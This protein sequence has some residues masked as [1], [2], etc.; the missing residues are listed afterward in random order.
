[1]NNN[2]D[3]TCVKG[4]GIILMVLG[5]CS[6]S[7]PYVTQI[8]YMFHMPL[9]FFFSGYCFKE[10]YYYQ[11]QKFLLRRIKGL[12][13][14]YVKWSLIFLLFHNLFFYLNIYNSTYG[15][16]MGSDHIYSMQE[17]LFKAYTITTHMTGHEQ[18][19]GGYWFLR[20]LF[21][22]SILSFFSLFVTHKI[23]KFYHC[24]ELYLEVGVLLLMVTLSLLISYYKIVIPYFHCGAHATHAA[25]FYLIGH[26]FKKYK[27]RTLTKKE[28]IIAFG[29]VILGSFF[30]RC[31]MNSLYYD[32]SKMIPFIVTAVVGTW[33]LY[34]LPWSSMKGG[35][36]L[37]IA[38][39]H[40][41]PILTWHFLCFK[42]ITLCIIFMY[43]LSINHL[44]EYPVIKYFAEK[45]W[46]LLYFFSGIG[47]PLFISIYIGRIK[48][49]Y[50]K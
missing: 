25:T 49:I 18:L 44:A 43:G 22:G 38:G 40:T 16:N 24:N 13:W 33:C 31:D 14:P 12:Y 34:S 23:S 9:F 45:G 20:A 21:Y 3:I 26:F 2:S 5:H 42:I 7:L 50:S 4:I 29:L 1:M 15:T 39:E 8:I 28:S 10:Q 47:I 35:A 32:N 46:W 27:V 17:F 37:Y 11:P 48:M 6:C 30:W 36:L 19:I 41:L